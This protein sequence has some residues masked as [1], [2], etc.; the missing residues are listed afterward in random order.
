M[1][2][3]SNVKVTQAVPYTAIGTTTIAG[4]NL[5]MSGFDG[6]MFVVGI[7]TLTDGTPGV[8]ASSGAASDGSDKQ[9]LLG[10][11]TA[12]GT[13]DEVSILDLYRP[14]DRYVTPQVVRG[15]STGSIITGLIAI[16]YKAGFKPTTQD[17]TTV[18]ATKL[19][20]SPAYGT[21]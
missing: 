19:V 9:D 15:G 2:L 16:Q 1:S 6:V 18:S 17:A 5:D 7:H 21:A 11:L 4:T 3:A 8:K 10:T 14:A 20:T 12:V 13:A